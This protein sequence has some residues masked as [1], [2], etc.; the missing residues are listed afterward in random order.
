MGTDDRPVYGAE[1]MGT[2]HTT[3]RRVGGPE[4]DRWAADT[5]GSGFDGVNE[6]PHLATYCNWHR[7]GHPELCD[8][9]LFTL[10]IYPID[11]MSEHS[12]S[13]MGVQ[14]NK[15]NVEEL[16]LA[17]ISDIL[18]TTWWSILCLVAGIAVGVWIKPWIM[19]KLK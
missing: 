15:E 11:P 19:G 9:C 5:R 8:E 17:T 4:L 6:G 16:M 13:Y 1:L 12:L 18:G 2:S 14:T 10:G 3:I 7:L